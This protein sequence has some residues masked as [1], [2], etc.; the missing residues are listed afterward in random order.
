M[1]GPLAAITGIAAGVTLFRFGRHVFAE[2]ASRV[3][4]VSI[5]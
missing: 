4:E 5:V 1:G 2:S 3:S